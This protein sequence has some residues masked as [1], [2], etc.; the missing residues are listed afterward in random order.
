MKKITTK[1]FF[2]IILC[3]ILFALLY[4]I[5]VKKLNE[6][7]QNISQS[8]DINKPNNQEIIQRSKPKIPSGRETYQIVQSA[9]TL[10]KI[11]EATID[12]PDVHVGDTQYLSLVVSGPDKIE[13]VIAYIETDN[14]TTTLPL[15]F[16]EEV[17]DNDLLPQNYALD[18]NNKLIYL[19]N[20]D[21]NN[22]NKNLAATIF[23]KI[24]NLK[25]NFLENASAQ[26]LYKNEDKNIEYPKL[27]YENS[28]VVRDTHDKYYHT[29]FVVRD[30]A[31]R[32]NSITLA[33]SDACSIPNSGAWTISSNCTI[34]STDGV[35]NGNVTIKTYT[36]T[37]NSTFA[38]N[39]GYSININ[40]GSIAIGSGGQLVQ[41]YLWITDYDGDNYAPSNY[42]VTV[43][44]SKPSGYNR[45]ALIIATS[46]CDDN[47]YNTW[48][49]DYLY[50]DDD[51]DGYTDSS[52]SVNVCIGNV[53]TTVGSR[54]YYVTVG[55]VFGNNMLGNN[56][57]NDMSSSVWR[58]RYR[59]AD[60]DGYGTS[61]P[62]CVGNQ[63]GYVD[64]NTDCDDTTSSKWQLLT[65]YSDYDRDGYGYQ[66]SPVY[67]VCSGSSLP[68]GYASNNTDCDD[69]TS[70][71]WQLLTGYLDSDGD[72]YGAQNSP[73][74]YNICSGSSLPSGLSLNNTDCYDGNANAYPGSYYIGT[75]DRGDGSFDYNC[76]GYQYKFRGLMGACA[77]ISISDCL[78]LSEPYKTLCN[79]C[80]SNC[81]A[82]C[83]NRNSGWRSD[84]AP[85]GCVTGIPDCGQC[86]AY[87]SGPF[88]SPNFGCYAC[89][90]WYQVTQ[91]CY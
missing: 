83:Q 1:L 2:I 3:I 24:K 55:G 29:I 42:S 73:A 66:N 18:Y 35:E 6:N 46:D 58:L 33:W 48:R 26:N 61:N 59:D 45:R 13:S 8:V 21:L 57:C 62:T 72:G 43:A 63:S 85:S 16:K 88:I 86:G 53:Y 9:E 49:Y 80:I 39:P 25:L 54:T 41:S 11:L 40:S 31:G 50:S 81:G 60:G 69:T 90:M 36:L 22:E 4:I 79:N 56:D 28:W 76:D 77:N 71:K 91:S 67:N 32:E 23:D 64:N 68:S 34:S 87:Y 74:F 15:N 51:F 12:S 47:D 84:W 7:N 78:N 75:V 52:S 17:S 27:K 14:G 44:D 5:G 38:W 82:A 30:S 37:L 10:P 65:G 89:N 70:S 19:K 20:Q